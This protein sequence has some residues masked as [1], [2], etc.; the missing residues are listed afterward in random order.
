MTIFFL[1]IGPFKCTI[2]PLE[3]GNMIPIYRHFYLLKQLL[4]KI[5][6]SPQ[7]ILMMSVVDTYKLRCYA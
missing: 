5:A 4:L 7:Y 2:I 1:P 3:E 6:N